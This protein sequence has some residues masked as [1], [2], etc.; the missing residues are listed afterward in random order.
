MMFY[1]IVTGTDIPVKKFIPDWSIGRS[2]GHVRNRLMGDYADQ[3]VVIYN[4]SRG[5]QGMID[6]MKKLNKRCIVVKITNN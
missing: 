1:L 6:Y 5:S 3:A 4:G 2:A